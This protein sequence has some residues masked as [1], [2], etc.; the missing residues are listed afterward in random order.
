MQLEIG[1]RVEERWKKGRTNIRRL[2][3][4]GQRN[5][6]IEKEER[7]EMSKER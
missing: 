7:W 4:D 1:E 2:H 6:D 3:Y 5:R